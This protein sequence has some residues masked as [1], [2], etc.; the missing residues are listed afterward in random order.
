[1]ACRKTRDVASGQ[2][3]DDTER[4]VPLARLGGTVRVMS[5]DDAS[6]DLMIA[7]GRRLEAIRLALG[8]MLRIDMTQD[9]M[10]NQLGVTRSGY[11]WWERGGRLAPVPAMLRLEE[12]FGI[13]LEWIYQGRLRSVPYDLARHLEKYAGFVGAPIGAAV[14]EFPTEAAPR[15]GRPPGRTPRAPSGVTLHEPSGE[16]PT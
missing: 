9:V 5:K 8:E 13:P 1:M 11:S 15:R 16:P 7:V 3:T 10:A 12:R 4:R 14:A 6:P 2:E